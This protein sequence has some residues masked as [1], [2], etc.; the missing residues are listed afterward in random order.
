MYPQS[1]SKFNEAVL[2]NSVKNWHFKFAR[3]YVDKK[4]YERAGSM[5][6]RLLH[7]FK[8]DLEAGLEYASMEL[9]E[10][11]N[12][13]KAEEITRRFVLDHHINSADGLLLLGDIFL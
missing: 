6:E 3:A 2:Y 9:E 5:Y 1:E 7:N 10:R 8:Y 13:E 12:Y 4:Q 11:A